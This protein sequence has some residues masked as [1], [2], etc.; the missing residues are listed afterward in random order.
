[1]VGPA[2]ASA[3]DVIAVQFGSL[4]RNAEQIGLAAVVRVIAAFALHFGV[5]KFNKARVSHLMGI[6][7]NL[8]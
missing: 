5:T 1:M 4:I 3:L 7:G 8:L 2:A 6:K